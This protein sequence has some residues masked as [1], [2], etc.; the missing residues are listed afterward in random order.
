L[1]KDRLSLADFVVF[2]RKETTQVIFPAEKRP[3]W[4]PMNA[5][6]N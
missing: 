3:I 1:K 6:L 5:C 4:L 2:I